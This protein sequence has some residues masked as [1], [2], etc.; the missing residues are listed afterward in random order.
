MSPV[1]LSGTTV[2]SA[3]LHNADQIN[4]LGLRSGDFVFIEK[5]GEIIP[6]VVGVDE[7]SRAVTVDLFN[8][9]E[10]SFP[11]HCLDCGTELVREQGEVVYYCPNT[12]ACPLRLKS[13]IKAFH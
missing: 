11:T 9:T 13:R 6:K 7:S 2:K 1:L 8:Q 3:T 10:S 12:E 5:G 4:R